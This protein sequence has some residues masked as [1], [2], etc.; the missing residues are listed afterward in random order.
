MTTNGYSLVISSISSANLEQEI[1]QLEK[2]QS[3]AGILL[4]GTNLNRDEI[5]LIS[6]IQPNLVVLDTCFETLDINFVVINNLYGAY[7][8]GE[9]LI[10]LGHKKIGYVASKTRI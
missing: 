3:S 6:G 9:Y 4:L 1:I 2:N 5:K 8:A 7:Q 10:S